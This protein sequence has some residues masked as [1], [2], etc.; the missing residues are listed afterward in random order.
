MGILDTGFTF[1]DDYNLSPQ[2]SELWMKLFVRAEKIDRELCSILMY[3]RNTGAKLIRSRE[4]GYVIRPVIGV[5]GFSTQEE[6]EH[7][8]ECLNPYRDE[9][10]KLLQELKWG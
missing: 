7:E 8:R 1:H 10:I 4:Y 5:D 3:V 9:I 6:Y 2:D